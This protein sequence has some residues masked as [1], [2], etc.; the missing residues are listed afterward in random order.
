MVKHIIVWK[1]KDEISNADEIK[2][3]IKSSLEGL[4]GVIDGLVEMHI[5]TQ[6]LP[7]SSGD[8]AMESLFENKEALEFYQKH[9]SHVEIA[10]SLV[11]PNVS[12][13]LSFDCEA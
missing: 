10:N 11:R 6:K 4:V 3:K 7:S 13:R 9:P 8:I 12:L 5:L 2:K 1:L